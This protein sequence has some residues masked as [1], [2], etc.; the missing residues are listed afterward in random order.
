MN[1][2]IVANAS[3]VGASQVVLVALLAVVILL[4]VRAVGHVMG[5][6]LTRAVSHML[7]GSIVVLFLLFIVLV[8]VRFKTVG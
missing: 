4:C 3:G 5:V 1:G 6:T 2:L 8:I 7:D